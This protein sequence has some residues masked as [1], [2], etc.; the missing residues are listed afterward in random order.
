MYDDQSAKL[1]PSLPVCL[2]TL[3]FL[4]SLNPCMMNAIN[5]NLDIK[6]LTIYEKTPQGCVLDF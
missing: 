5:L 6:I 3:R 2:Q 4:P 1:S